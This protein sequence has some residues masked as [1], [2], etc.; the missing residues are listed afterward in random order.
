MI[1]APIGGASIGGVPTLLA[2]IVSLA[3]VARVAGHMQAAT[4][5]GASLRARMKT[6]LS[7]RAVRVRGNA[8]GQLDPS[9]PARLVIVP[10]DERTI[11]VPADPRQID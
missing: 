5:A 1:G 11:A 10:D 8:D 3:G 9:H 7:A 6:V 4:S 2:P